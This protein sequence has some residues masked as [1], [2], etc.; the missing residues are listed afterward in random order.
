[1]GVPRETDSRDFLRHLN[2][3]ICGNNYKRGVEKGKHENLR[4]WVV[5]ESQNREKKAECLLT[6]KV[7]WRNIVSII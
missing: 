7:V 2:I 4:D 6:K 1:M 5:Y 3:L